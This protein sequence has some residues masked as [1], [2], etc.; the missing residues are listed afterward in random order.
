[1]NAKVWFYPKDK[2]INTRRG[3]KKNQTKAGEKKI[4]R[5]KIYFSKHSLLKIK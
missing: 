1:M 5:E 3:R 4:N 2:K